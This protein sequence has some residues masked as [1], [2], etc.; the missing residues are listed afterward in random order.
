MS[1]LCVAAELLGLLLVSVLW[2]CTNPLLK[3]GAQGI[4]NVSKPNRLLQLLAE[5]KFLFLNF[6]VNLEML[7][8]T[9]YHLLV[10]F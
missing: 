6:K 10:Y 3:R 9:Q 7:F 2:G 5:V 1:W 8:S 4:E